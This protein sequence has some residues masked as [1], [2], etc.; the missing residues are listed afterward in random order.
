MGFRLATAGNENTQVRILPVPLADNPFQTRPPRSSGV[1][2]KLTALSRP[3]PRFESGLE[4]SPIVRDLSL[5]ADQTE[6]RIAVE[7]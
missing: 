3:T 2:A 1:A 7:N 5:P 6:G 4:H